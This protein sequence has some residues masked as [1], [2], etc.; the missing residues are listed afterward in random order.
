MRWWLVL[1][2][3]CRREP[4]AASDAAPATSVTAQAS[5]PCR[6]EVADKKETTKIVA[7]VLSTA[8][9]RKMAE[10]AL[11]DALPSAV[12]CLHELGLVGIH[13]TLR[14]EISL[15]SSGVASVA[16]GGD[17]PVRNCLARAIKT[18]KVTGSG[19]IQATYDVETT[20]KP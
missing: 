10:K 15:D 1:L 5:A 4:V 9:D 3:A 2:M 19:S 14:A 7:T 11:C 8:V 17:D 6:H 20:M 18:A 16:L 13:D 12:S